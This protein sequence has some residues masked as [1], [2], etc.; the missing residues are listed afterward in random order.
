MRS[1]SVDSHASQLT[2]D[3]KLT[4]FSSLHDE[5]SPLAKKQVI[6]TKEGCLDSLVELS[7]ALEPYREVFTEEVCN[8]VHQL[9]EIIAA[10]VIKLDATPSNTSDYRSKHG[11]TSPQSIKSSKAREKTAEM[12]TLSMENDDLDYE[13]SILETEVN[14]LAQQ[15]SVLLIEKDKLH[16][17]TRVN[18]SEYQ[19]ELK[20]LRKQLQK[21]K[22]DYETEHKQCIERERQ[23]QAILSQ[24]YLLREDNAATYK[25]A[26]QLEKTI[27]KGKCPN[28]SSIG[29]Y[30]SIHSK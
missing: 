16:Y 5:I 20:I 25:Y 19:H 8:Q 15:N 14:K 22:S 27:A 3:P 12:T 24:C 9:I 23:Y 29:G 18:Q 11:N 1:E 10:Y 30:P 7:L 26:Q 13:K 4:S 17:T 21:Y 2:I 6:H 28:C